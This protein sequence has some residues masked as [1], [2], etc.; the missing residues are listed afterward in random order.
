[1]AAARDM[2][3]VCGVFESSS[4]AR[5]MRMPCSLQSAM[6][7][8]SYY[9]GR[10]SLLLFFRRR[11]GNACGCC[12]FRTAAQNESIEP[13]EAAK[14]AQ[15]LLQQHYSSPVIPAETAALTVQG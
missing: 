8:R 9:A 11:L 13:V 4:P 10:I 12:G 3:G 15:R 5:T 2:P 7:T 1:M 14:A 6:R